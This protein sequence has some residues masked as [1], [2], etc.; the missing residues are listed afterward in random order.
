MIRFLL[1]VR[2][3]DTTIAADGGAC[4]GVS[5]ATASHAIWLWVLMLGSP[6]RLRK[7]K[8]YGQATKE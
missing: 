2:W 1:I 8:T 3:K 5:V 7:L 4:G 6:G